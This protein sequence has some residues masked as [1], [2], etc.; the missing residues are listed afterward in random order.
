[1]VCVC[2]QGWC[3]FIGFDWCG[4]C[5]VGCGFGLE[6]GDMGVELYGDLG[7]Y[8]GSGLDGVE[9]VVHV[10][11]QDQVGQI[12]KSGWFV[13]YGDVGQIFFYGVKG[14]FIFVFGSVVGCLFINVVGCL[15]VVIN[16]TCFDYLVE[17]FMVGD[18]LQGGG[19][20]I[21]NGIVFDDQVRFEELFMFY[22]GSNLFLLV[23]GGVI[24]LCDLCHQVEELQFN[25]GVFVEFG[26]VDWVLIEFILCENEFLFGILLECLFIVDGT[27]LVFE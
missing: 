1:M 16:G 9:V 10:D 4:G 18:L 20:V 8:F 3:Y 17:S 23:L 15:C 22:L 26:V 7:D 11:V 19:F 27:C 21:V 25:G 14:G 6:S 24:Y 5:F 12:L 13:I 2:E